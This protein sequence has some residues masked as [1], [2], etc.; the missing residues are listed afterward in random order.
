MIVKT[1]TQ[2]VVVR[3]RINR[4]LVVDE[5]KVTVAG[6]MAHRVLTAVK[7]IGNKLIKPSVVWDV[8]SLH[9]ANVD[10]LI[11]VWVER[12]YDKAV[13]RKYTKVVLSA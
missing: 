7:M 2:T 6:N 11:A 4:K 3:Q 5:W 10:R 12:Q 1:K 13:A 8:T 9:I